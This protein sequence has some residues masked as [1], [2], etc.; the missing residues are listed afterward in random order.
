ML[1]RSWSDGSNAD[2]ILMA[3]LVFG[4]ALLWC[5]FWLG[6]WHGARTWKATAGEYRMLY[7]SALRDLKEA[8]FENFEL[9]ERRTKMTKAS[10]K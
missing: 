2:L 4:L 9:R 5:V 10:E 3:T 6:H 1:T 7:L 8:G